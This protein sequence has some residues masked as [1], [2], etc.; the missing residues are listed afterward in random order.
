MNHNNIGKEDEALPIKAFKQWNAHLVANQIYHA[1]IQK[2]VE[3][4]TNLTPNQKIG[5][6]ATYLTEKINSLSDGERARL[7]VL[8]ERWKEEGPPE[9]VKH[10]LVFCRIVWGIYLAYK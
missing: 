2:A 8:A 9:E 5:K 4:H 1:E 3:A 10:Q 7:A 6:W